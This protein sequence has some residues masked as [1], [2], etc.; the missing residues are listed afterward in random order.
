LLTALLIFFQ[1]QEDS[2]KAIRR[3]VISALILG[4]VGFATNPYFAF[5]IALVM[6]ATTVSL[7]WK[8]RL[9]LPQAAGFLAVLGMTCIASSYAI[10]FI[11]AGGRGYGGHGYRVYSMN[12]LSPVD[13]GWF[14]SRIFPLLVPQLEKGEYEGYNYLGAGAIALALIVLLY[15]LRRRDK[16]HALDARWVIP[17]LACCL[18]L[19]S[20]ALTT[21]I[22]VGSRV[23]IDVDPH[24]LLSR[25]L[26]P[27]R[28][29]GRLFWVPYYTLLIGLLAA[30]YLFMRQ[31][32]ANALL[33]CLLILQV[34]D[35]APLR[36]WT[37]SGVHQQFPEPLKSPI[38]H[39]LGSVYESLV[40]LPAWQCGPRSSPGGVYGYR[41]FGYLA[42]EQ[43]MR[44]NS[45]Y[46][47]RYT[48]NALDYHCKQS[49]DGLLSKPLSPDTAYVVTPEVA[50]QIAKGP[51]GDGKCHDLDQ[52][53]LCSPKTDFG[54][55]SALKEQGAPIAN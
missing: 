15:V 52:F 39:Q 4:A 30:P 49:M 34:A 43:K 12:L 16:L 53:I 10:G 19:T 18:V 46:T 31:S 33:L 22:Q 7:F 9:S 55:N 23:L 29:S 42:T 2:P 11:I 47:A 51:T 50:A 20:M 27:M 37:Y 1:A 26:A 3:F 41:Y 32:R 38:W 35:T 54:L 25:F 13:P 44:T 8:R 45:Y 36:R 6:T 24:Q 5:P 21:K 40:V 48:G 14:G 17:L 28:S